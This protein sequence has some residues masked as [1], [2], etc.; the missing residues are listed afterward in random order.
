MVAGGLLVFTL[1]GPFAWLV[2]LTDG[3]YAAAVIGAAAGWGAWPALALCPPQ[4]RRVRQFILATALGAGVLSLLVMALGAA[5]ILNKPV[6]VGLLIAGGAP[7]L[8]RLYLRQS[9]SSPGRFVPDSDIPAAEAPP[10]TSRVALLAA[11]AGGAL[12]AIPLGVMFSGA[13]LPPSV[14]WRGEAGGY[15]ALEYHLQVPREWFENGRITFLPHNVYASFPQQMEMQYL[16]LMHLF[17]NP[18]AAAISCQLLHALYGV[19]FLLALFAWCDKPWAGILAVV[20]AGTVPWVAYVGCLAYVENGLLFFAAV[21]GGLLSAASRGAAADWRTCLTAGLCAGFAAGCKYQGLVF[22]VAALALAF[23]IVQRCPMKARFGRIGLFGAGALLAFGPWL[24]RNAV[25]TGN[26]VY[27]FAYEVFGGR[28]WSPEQAEQ[29]QRGHSVVPRFD[30][31][32][33]RLQLAG[34]ELIGWN[35]TTSAASFGDGPQFGFGILLAS[36][37]AAATVRNRPATLHVIWSAAIL[38]G[39]FGFTHMPGRFAMPLIVPLCF[40]IAGLF[41]HREARGPGSIVRLCGGTAVLAGALLMSALTFRLHWLESWQ[42]FQRTQQVP[43][44]AVFGLTHELFGSFALNKTLPENTRPWLV[45]QAAVFPLKA[46]A[47]YTVVF[48]RDPWLVFCAAG[49]SPA[50]CVDWL[51]VRGYS[52]VVFDGGEITRLGAT[53]GFPA[54]VTPAWVAGLVDGGLRPAAVDSTDLRA[55]GLQVFEILRR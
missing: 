12:L 44:S 4:D 41:E 26:P 17:G 49:K 42:F 23:L 16:L 11:I 43:M 38:A 40:L 35:S 33:G 55:G 21:A 51:R 14:L 2:L 20:A 30:S 48:N 34:A 32:V 24:I 29:W 7:G 31:L 10:R 1:L 36:L 15:D 13:C 18:Q 46:R 54:I 6:A 3:V 25:F 19:L 28:D 37:I 47:A 5:G 53:Y 45:G 52:H 9:K 50:E 8:A 22:V 27:P 39:W